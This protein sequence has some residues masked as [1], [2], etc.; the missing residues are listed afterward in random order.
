MEPG[1]LRVQLARPALVVE[2]LA[3]ERLDPAPELEAEGLDAELL[4]LLGP[5]DPVPRPAF[6]ILD[7]AKRVVQVLREPPCFLLG[8]S[9][10]LLAG[11]KLRLQL[12]DPRRL[13]GRLREWTGRPWL[14]ATEGGGGGESLYERERRR[15]NEERASIEADP[16]VLAVLETFPGAELAHIK[17]LAPAP[18][19]APVL[20][21]VEP[22]ED[23]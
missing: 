23:E 8:R 20:G 17:K 7:L 12:R 18:V 19:E 3:Q 9:P 16:F 10:R 15:L 11:S 1:L 13:V 2:H 6:R 4:L 21:D 22:T 5:V 14:V